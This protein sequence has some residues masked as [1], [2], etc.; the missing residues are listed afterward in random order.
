MIS[1]PNLADRAILAWPTTRSR[2]WLLSFLER[3]QRQENV[4]AVVAVGSTV[5]MELP[6]E[7]LDLVVVCR[8]RS[9]FSE[10]P[11]IEVD[12]R[13]F[14]LDALGHH[15]EQGQDLLAWAVRFGKPVYDEA[16]LWADFVSRWG[17]RLPLPDVSVARARADAARVQREAMRTAGDTQAAADLHISYLTHLARAALAEA[18]V[19]PASR[20]ELRDQLRGIGKSK[21][22]DRLAHALAERTE[23][24][25]VGTR[26]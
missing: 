10:K 13:S 6:P 14:D 2:R 20:P 23:R 8:D 25:A 9:L 3:V 1:V 12:L 7:D 5:R 21:L 18:G 22:G 24:R 4:V 11:P 16:G 26:L 15:L 17:H 19:F